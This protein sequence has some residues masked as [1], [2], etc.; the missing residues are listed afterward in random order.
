MVF[1]SILGTILAVIEIKIV[2]II[3]ANAFV[4]NSI[5]TSV[6]PIINYVSLM[7]TLAWALLIITVVITFFFVMTVVTISRPISEI[8]TYNKLNTSRKRESIRIN[9]LK[10]FKNNILLSIPLYLTIVYLLNPENFFIISAGATS[11]ASTINEFK[12]ALVII[13]G[14]L[15][16]IRLLTNPVK[17]DSA[18]PLLRPLLSMIKRYHSDIASKPNL[19]E[20]IIS[21]YFALT[22]STFFLMIMLV[23]YKSIPLATAASLSDPLNINFWKNVAQIFISSVIPQF[24]PDIFTNLI[25]IILFIGAYLLALFIQTAFGEIILD[26]YQLRDPSD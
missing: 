24:S 12:A 25:T 5:S 13:P 16:S 3:S 6:I 17:K 21:F 4:I 18:Y 15:L 1:L 19:K 26:H 11:S 14:Y 8:G 7:C 20:R 2:T 22:A 9:M 10:T 23:L